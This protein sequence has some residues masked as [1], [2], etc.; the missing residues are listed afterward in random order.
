MQKGKNDFS[1]SVLQ[2]CLQ[3]CTEKEDTCISPLFCLD[4]V[5]ETVIIIEE[6]AEQVVSLSNQKDHPSLKQE[7]LNTKMKY[8]ICQL[9]EVCGTQ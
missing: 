3:E 1:S 6:S 4:F 9:A 2:Y 7:A 8:G 5:F